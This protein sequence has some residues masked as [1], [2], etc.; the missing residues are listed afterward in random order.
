[1]V[2]LSVGIALLQNRP[3]LRVLIVDKEK[4]SGLHASGR[5]S[6]VL[7]SGFYYSPDSLKA[8]FCKDGNLELRKLA[9]KFAIPVRDVGKVVVARDFEEDQRLDALFDR[10]ILNGVDLEILT[11]EK[12][13]TFE[14]LA[15]THSRFIWS[16]TTA[17][18]D[19]KAVLEAMILE[20]IAHGGSIE[21][22]SR[23]KL[24][25]K[26][27]QTY[28]SENRYHFK[29]IINAAGAQADKISRSL[30]IG[31]EYAMLPFMGVY[32]ATGAVNLPLKRLVYPVPHPINPFLGVHFTLSIHGDI[33]IGPTAIPVLGREQY[34][35]FQG[36]SYS[37]LYQS[38]IAAS[39]LVQGNSHSMASIIRLEWPKVIQRNL[40]QESSRLVPLA[41]NVV[42]WSR[43]KPG[44]RAQ[45][46]HLES[47]KLEQDFV[48]KSENNSTHI[49]NAVSPGW[50][51]ALPFGRWVAEKVIIKLS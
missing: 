20:F 38:V 28:D 23:I 8:K 6:G 51:S 30:G 48:V 33:K 39:S 50:T 3:S 18:S 45:L 31:T 44:I 13:N 9:S 7:H 14:P 2:G 47:G 40:V 25:Q 46:V 19:P 12:L 22:N 42:K 37:D 32:S 49:L 35:L 17:I 43:K 10:G 1:V 21:F 26:N 27:S 24:A 34:S 5:N 15:V 4:L 29:P 41:K 36:W 16:P 11:K